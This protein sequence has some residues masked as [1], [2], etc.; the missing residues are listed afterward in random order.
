MRRFAVAAAVV[1]LARIACADD[2]TLRVAETV[3]IEIPGTTAA[4]AVDPAIADVTM[5]SGGR[6]TITGRSAG[7]TQIIAITA[8]G[9]R[10]YL[11]TISAAAQRHLPGA[12]ATNAPI[13]RADIRYAGGAHQVQSAFDVFTSDGERRSQ[14]HLLNVHY[15]TESF[16]RST[17]AIPSIYYRTTSGRRTL[18]L[19]DDFID[20]S[21]ITVRS[22][23][24]RGVHLID[25]SFVLHAGYAASTMYEDL[26]LPADKRWMA[27]AGYAI[28]RGRFRW[29]PSAYAFLSEPRG[30]A[31][32]RGVVASLATE[33]RDGEAL[34]ARGE[35]AA[36]R[37]VAGSG[38]VRY[39]TERDQLRGRLFYKPN[40]FPT[41]GLSDLPG[42]H[43]EF[44]WSRHATK[45]LSVDSYAT[46]DRTK[47]AAF[48]QTVGVANVA[49]RYAVTPHVSV[50]TGADSSV[51][52]SGTNASIRTIGIPAGVSYDAQRFGAAALYRLLDNSQTSRRGDSLRLSGR[53]GSGGL[54]VNAWVE[55]Q[56]R[57]PSLD[58]IF[59]D[60]PGLELALL[61]LGITVR[62]PEDLSRVLRDNAALINLGYIDG[63]TVNLTPRRVQS[64]I[65]A[66]FNSADTRNQLRLHAVVDRSEGVASTQE[67]MLATL[68]YTRRLMTSTDIYGSYSRWR[69]SISSRAIDG[70]SIELGVRHRF[71]GLPQFLQ[72]SGTIEGLVFLDPQQRG[73]V[74]ETTTPLDGILVMLDD[75]R[76][77]RSAKNGAYA[78]RGVPPG[79]HRVSAKIGASKPAYFTTPSTAELSASGH[80]DFGLVW[81]PARIIGRVVSDANLGIAGA[82]LN[83][84][85]TKG[86]DMSATTDSEG[87][88]VLA[89]P[90]GEYTIDLAA[91]SLP[92]GYTIKG[93]SKRVVNAPADQPKDVAFDVQ[94]LRSVA[95]T[96]EGGP[97]EVRIEPLGL[98]VT[99][100]A[101]GNYVFRSLPPGTFTITARRG[102]RVASRTITVPSEPVILNAPLVFADAPPP[103]ATPRRAE[104]SVPAAVR[105]F[106]VQLGAFREA[107]NAAELID[108]VA[109]TGTHAESVQTDGLILVRVGP[110]DSRA[111]ATKTTAQLREKGF[112][113]I[114]TR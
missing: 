97:A 113:A 17:N 98:T 76:S 85:T 9:T 30:T 108:R 78:F 41:L 44:D 57:A 18:T 26:F 89:G 31:A 43:G 22:T 82:V 103:T 28:D 71:D 101:A 112:E 47:I 40:D 11:I 106:F 23:Q 68:S 73:V 87:G 91:E 37:G 54:T 66:A 36:G 24:V 105:S 34:F 72:R 46:Y 25:G 12:L 55:R 100:D 96:V 14:F 19:L 77:T 45:R 48:D 83:A 20:L 107:R 93:T 59:R 79:R 67:S 5:A 15:L 94:A 39:Q 60:T 110:Y 51:V 16:G 4:Y 70:S 86:A 49:L 56:R 53:A 88:F 21:P 62:T 69:T 3:T 13:A 8:N 1:F 58:L 27:S 7:T 29:I 38:E 75:T 42:V 63:V 102:E 104:A 64:G 33:Y 6:V 2:V 10:A 81:S 111:A 109:R 114:V 50:L 90:A 65:D 74:N 84:R 80:A 92:A 52:R 99:S 61:R 95:G 32:R 35:M